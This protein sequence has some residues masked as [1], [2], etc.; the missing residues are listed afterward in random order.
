MINTK[1]GSRDFFRTYL[2]KQPLFYALVRGAECRLFDSLGPLE[3]PVLDLGC[4]NG[5]F[6]STAFSERLSVG[7]DPDISGLKEAWDLKVHQHA[8]TGEGGRLPFRKKSF[9]TVIANSVLEHIQEIEEALKEINRVLVPGGAF[10]FTVPSHEFA[11]HLFFSA[12]LRN[13][14]CHQLA[15]RY[16]SWFNHHSRHFHTDPPVIWL[17]RLAR[18][19]FEPESWRYYLTPAAHRAF[20]LAHY[21]SLPRLI[22]K[23][24]SGKWV[25]FPGSFTNLLWEIWLRPHYENDS[26]SK[27]P[28]IFFRARKT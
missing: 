23:K 9:H 21:F 20:D 27:G 5:F 18:H 7:I 13:L 25:L 4:G 16:G 26:S 15:R 8:I 2:L 17:A 28:Y 11:R 24:L 22:S 19:G 10:L 14:G 3:K 1:K 6:A 12:L